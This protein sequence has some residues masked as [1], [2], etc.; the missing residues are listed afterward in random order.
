MSGEAIIYPAIAMFG[1]T[2]VVLVMLGTARYKA[3]RDR[4]VSI[5]YF[6]SYNEGEQ[7]DRLHLMSRH[8]QN[9]FEVPPIF[10]AAVLFTYVTGSVTVLSVVL[11]WIFV[12]LRCVHSFIHL[13]SNN[14]LHRFYAFIASV[15][16]LVGIW[17]ALLVS[18]MRAGS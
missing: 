4:R 10:Y 18:L 2:L 16:C 17:G 13:G 5:R 1:L 15:A 9:H 6:R 7:P 11:A 12:G 8:L 3:V 14:V